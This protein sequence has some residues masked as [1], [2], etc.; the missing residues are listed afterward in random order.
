MGPRARRAIS[1]PLARHAWLQQWVGVE[2]SP[3]QRSLP[4]PEERAMSHPFKVGESYRNRDGEY[5]VLELNG[6]RMV[7][8][9]RGGR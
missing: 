8:R 5:D 3:N 1:Q 7:I 6:P 2:A 9:Y 4:N